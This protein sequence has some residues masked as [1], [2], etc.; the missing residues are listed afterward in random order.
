MFF[1]IQRHIKFYLS[2][3]HPV[4][5]L[6]CTLFKYIPAIATDNLCFFIVAL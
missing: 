1:W 6:I 5:L 2:G 3:M 4:A